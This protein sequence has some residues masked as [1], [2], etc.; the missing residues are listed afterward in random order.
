MYDLYL[1]Y[2]KH[3]LLFFQIVDKCGHPKRADSTQAQVVIP[4]PRTETDI[5]DSVTYD[6]SSSE[7]SKSQNMYSR[8]ET[9]MRSLMA[10]KGFYHSLADT[11]CSAEKFATG[12]DQD[13]CWNGETQAK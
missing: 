10:S 3:H 4:T 1:V 12:L 11:M 7:D 2:F 5:K 13:R 9:F 8:I 6:D